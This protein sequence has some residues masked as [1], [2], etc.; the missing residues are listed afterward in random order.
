M[1]KRVHNRL[2]ALSVQRKKKSG[3]YSDGGGLYLRVSPTGSR[4]WLFRY[5]WQGK[6]RDMGLGSAAIISLAQARQ[7]AGNARTYLSEG[8]DPIQVRRQS[9]AALVASS[10]TFKD[11]AEAYI[12]AHRDGWR[13]AKH[14]TQWNAKH[15]TQW[16]ATLKAYA[17]PVFGD[18]PQGD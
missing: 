4:S 14:A 12:A 3:L 9:E 13:N 10:M 7:K 18:L 2:T 8:R 15:A 17:Y 5:R 11:C 16:N 6:R 1:P